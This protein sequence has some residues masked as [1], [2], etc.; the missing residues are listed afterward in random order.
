MFSSITQGPIKAHDAQMLKYQDLLSKLEDI[1]KRI[2]TRTDI[3][4]KEK[5]EIDLTKKDNSEELKL[6]KTDI[7]SIEQT[8]LS[9]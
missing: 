2:E 1:E 9:K 8:G 6:I 5:K 3:I 7:T 4:E